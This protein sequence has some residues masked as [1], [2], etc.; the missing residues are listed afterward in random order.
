MDGSGELMGFMN[1]GRVE[2]RDRQ[3]AASAKRIHPMYGNTTARIRGRSTR[4][5]WPTIDFTT[6]ANNNIRWTGP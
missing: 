5:G 2:R 1:G 4:T 3:V 6:C